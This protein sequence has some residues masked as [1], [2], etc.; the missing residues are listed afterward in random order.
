MKEI[1]EYLAG[2]GWEF[3]WG[4]EG[5]RYWSAPSGKWMAC[6][7]QNSGWW[8]LAKLE[9]DILGTWKTLAEGETLAELL[10][11]LKEKTNGD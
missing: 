1:E 11:A 8:E 10:A 4:M 6:T 5:Q 9:D 2:L 3:D 7:N